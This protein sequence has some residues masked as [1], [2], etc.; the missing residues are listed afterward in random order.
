MSDLKVMF[1]LERGGMF[2][3]REHNGVVSGVLV[4]PDE[5]DRLVLAAEDSKR[6]EAADD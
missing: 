6:F 3:F 4:K 2:L 5:V 1:D